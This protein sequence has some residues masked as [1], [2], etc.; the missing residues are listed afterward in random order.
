MLCTQ[1]GARANTEE[2]HSLP[3]SPR[4]KKGLWG[5]QRGPDTGLA[6]EAACR[7]PRAEQGLASPLQDAV[8]SPEKGR[9]ESPRLSS[10][11]SLLCP[12]GSVAAA[13]P[14][15]ATGAEAV[16]PVLPPSC[17]QHR[18]QQGTERS[19]THHPA[20][21]WLVAR[22]PEPAQGQFPLH[23]HHKVSFHGN[24]SRIAFFQ[25]MGGR[26]AVRTCPSR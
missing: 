9:I 13:S 2:H 26:G 19:I 4:G 7:V 25:I 20:A 21:R 12:A 15:T 3:R 11:P 1:P 10:L 24:R 23:T 8:R 22:C 17:R 6:V 18:G 5:A 14:S 16:A